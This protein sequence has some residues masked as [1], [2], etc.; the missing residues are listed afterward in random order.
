MKMLKLHS[1]NIDTLFNR[2]MYYRRKSTIDKVQRIIEDVRMNG[3]AAVLKYTRRFDKARMTPKD[4]AVAESE[5]SGAFQ[6]ITPEF[7]STLKMVIN[8]VST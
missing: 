4:M 7:V 5:I 2:N 3:D 6:N 1:K 8:N